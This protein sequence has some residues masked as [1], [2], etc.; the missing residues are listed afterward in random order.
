[1]EAFRD[2][3]GTEYNFTSLSVRV[4]GVGRGLASICVLAILDVKFCQL[5]ISGCALGVV[6]RE[7]RKVDV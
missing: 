1:V 6:V 2:L 5:R 3:R 7:H 4:T